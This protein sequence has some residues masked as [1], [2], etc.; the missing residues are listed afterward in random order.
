M[1][2]YSEHEVV[3]FI[4]LQLAKEYPRPPIPAE[5]VD[6]RIA[7]WRTK[8][9]YDL[10]DEA[11]AIITQHVKTKIVITMNKGET[12]A[13]H[14]FRDWLQGRH[15]DILWKR[16][17][18]Y[19]QL[20]S[21]KGFTPRVQDALDAST[22]EILN[23][24]G[25]PTDEGSWK[26]RGLVIGD[27]QS[28][29]TATYIGAVNKAADAGYKLVILLAGGTEALRKQTQFR[30]D[31]G[32]IGRD[33]SKTA[34]GAQLSNNPLFG[35]GLWL[36]QFVSAQGL[37]TQATDFRKTS[38]HAMNIAIDPN[39]STPYVFVLKK[40]KTALENLRDWLLGQQLG[41]ARIDI[42]MLLVDDESDYASVNT[43]A[44]DSPTVINGLIRSILG[45]VS[46]SSYLAFTATPF[47]NVFIDHRTTQDLLGDDLFPRDYIRTID[48]PTNYVGSRAYF[49][50]E[51][52]VDDRKLV[53]LDDAE[54][55]FPLKHKSD[56]NVQNLP[57]SL[58]DA[59]RAFVV[60][61][62]VREARGDSSA[63]TMLVNVSRFKRVQAQVH[64]L[65]EEEFQRI[66]DAIELHSVSLL[67]QDRHVEIQALER[68]FER[69]YAGA[70]ETWNDI[71]PSLKAAVHATPVR[72]INSDR[73]K[74]VQD[75][76]DLEAER[77]I[78]VGGDVLSRGLT[79]DGLTVSYFHRSVGASDTLLQ[80]ARWFGYRPGYADLC[81]VWLPDDVADQFRYVAGIV[82]E[83]RGQLLAM[84]KQGLTPEDFGLMV[85]MHPE[86]LKI[87]STAKMGGAE[88]KPWTVDLAGRNIETTTVDSK[89]SVVAGNAAAVRDLV[90]NVQAAY[91]DRGWD[92]AR[93]PWP[94]MR[95]VDKLHIAEFLQGYVP[96]I[97]DALFADNV[98]ASHIQNSDHPAL[99]EWTVAFVQGRGERAAIGDRLTVL[100]P[101]RALKIGKTVS[102]PGSEATFVPFRVSGSSSRLAG[103]TDIARLFGIT[104]PD[105]RGEPRVYQ[106]IKDHGPALM[107]YL[108][109]P[110]LGRKGSES[111]RPNGA[112]VASDVSE[113][114]SEVATTAAE[115]ELRRLWSAVVNT[116]TRF[117]VCVKI[118]I[119]AAQAGKRGAEVRYMLNSV[120]LSS[121]K[122][123]VV[124]QTDPDDLHDLDL[125]DE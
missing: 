85:R 111:P 116:G 68:T 7:L 121:W 100:P 31:E 90:E 47:A 6:A 112:G 51:Q 77:M 64:Q 78:A 84:K 34:V 3:T 79:L 103:S 67:P 74:Q 119:P 39:T 35:V 71:I 69:H 24:L 94:V 53:V 17:I 15:A 13:G 123:S 86:T 65:V 5:A 46:K 21:Q 18:A 122:L 49:G 1:R 50:T 19:K 83:L 118:A 11:W 14:D 125:D 73:V 88:A 108:V 4:V 72:L 41:G 115:E 8:G 80:M 10:P 107:I 99:Q 66:K 28:G 56:Q 102:K 101:Q 59:I 23:C 45:T 89:P 114:Q 26:R 55:H 63:R 42:P 98:L 57:D 93:V 36:N 110:L 37:T 96:F 58:R 43:R 61:I 95:G 52:A 29:K 109:E 32:L 54:E 87:T 40:N 75:I 2:D 38:Q 20:L 22:D 82:D 92:D 124:E 27:V 62:A 120:A 106:A 33:S 91:P 97:T 113:R 76:A 117:L 81:R 9:M 104:D 105:L 16:W 70:M 30:I 44:D 25:D 12:L 60:A 48:P